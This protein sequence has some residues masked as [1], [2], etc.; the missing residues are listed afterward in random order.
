VLVDLISG[1]TTGNAIPDTCEGL[2]TWLTVGLLAPLEAVRALRPSRFVAVTRGLLP[3][4]PDEAGDP[5]ASALLGLQRC[6]PHEWP[7]L[8]TAVVDLPLGPPMPV[9]EEVEALVRE[10]GTV[11]D[12]DVAH[13]GG[14]RYRRFHEPVRAADRTPLRGGGVYLV[15][16][17]TGRLGA[18]VAD[19]IGAAARATVV[20]TGRSPGGPRPAHEQALLDS[21]RAQGCSVVERPLDSTDLSALSTLLDDLTARHGRV[22]GV[23]HLAAH[24]DV[25]CFPLLERLDATDAATVADA[26]VRSAANLAA[27]LAG[28]DYDFVL[29]F[30]SIST[31]IGALRFGP[32]VSANAYLDAIASQLWASGERRWTSVV[33]DS[34]TASGEPTAGALG[35]SDGAHLIREVLRCRAPVVFAVAQDVEQRRAAVIDDLATVADSSRAATPA[36]EHSPIS[37]S[38]LD[39]IENVTGHRVAD[40]S[41]RLVGLGIDSLQMMQIAARLRPLLGDRVPLGSVLAAKSV[42]DIVDLARPDLITDAVP[43]VSV[44]FDALSSVQQRLWYLAELEPDGASYNVPF[45]WRLP[46]SADLAAAIDAVRTVLARHESLRSVY[47]IASDGSPRRVVLGV[48]NVPV[49]QVALL[50]TDPDRDFAEAARGHVDAVFDLR[51]GAVRV[52]LGH[53]GGSGIRLLFVCHHIAVDAWSVRII[54]TDLRRALLSAD[55]EVRTPAGSYHDFVRWEHETRTTVD[56]P[57]HLAYWKKI[58]HGTRPTVPP[59]DGDVPPLESNGARPIG[60][61]HKVLSPEVVVRLREVLQAEGVTLYIAGLTGLALA[62]AQWSGDRDVVI[63]TNLA[64][65]WRPEF[66]HVVGMFV[67]PVVLRLTPTEGED[68]TRAKTVGDALAGVRARFAD[69]LEHSEVPFLD[70]VQHTERDRADSAVFSVMATMFD[71]EQGSDDQFRAIDVPLPATSKFPLAVEFLPA[72]HGLVVHVLYAARIVEYLE[73]LGVRGPSAPLEVF[74]AGASS[75]SER[76]ARFRRPTDAANP[77]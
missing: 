29:L 48:D 55:R 8:A 39:T 23:F 15:I 38:I 10:L 50:G 46:D 62:L 24:T 26:K 74:V 33:W 6:A 53:T 70:I 69:A 61:L 63:G 21:A 9:A 43:A 35:A 54:R 60:L 5:G 16:G 22:D 45:G 34:W 47:P 71:T 11:E 59:A 67:D 1:G 30:S 49:E 77:D 7:G 4:L 12:R 20:I 14:V 28:R 3:V 73:T 42:S 32:Y 56:Y 68:G 36:N 41:Q 76:F 75:V 17:G 65:R 13:R 72:P 52:L 27:A 66:E 58:V 2:K 44:E 51:R 57:H 18:V 64:N 25:A 40:V 19:A 31:L 37:R